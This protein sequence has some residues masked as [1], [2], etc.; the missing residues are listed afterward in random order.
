MVV[1]VANLIVPLF[2]GWEATGD[3]G[4]V[5]MVAATAVVLLLTLLV[6]PKWSELRMILVAGGIFTAVAQTLP[7]IQIIVGIMS[8]QT[9]RHLGFVQEYGYRLTELG[10]FL[11]TLLTACMMLAAA[12]MSGVFLRAVGRD[13]DRR[14]EAMVAW[15]NPTIGKSGGEL[16]GQQV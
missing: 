5:G 3:G 15:G 10:G 13:A 11:A 7:L 16:G 14:R 12:F 6:V 2:L 1:F 9:V 4:R 8:V